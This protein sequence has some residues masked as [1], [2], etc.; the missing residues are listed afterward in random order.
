MSETSTPRKTPQASDVPELKLKVRVDTEYGDG[1]NQGKP[2]FYKQIVSQF[3]YLEGNIL[4]IVDAAFSD[5]EQRKAVKDL[6]RGH[7]GRH[8]ND[9]EYSCFRGRNEDGSI[10]AHPPVV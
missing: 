5:R 2:I 8:L 10:P 3:R 7:I 1:E 9:I 4:T 6:V